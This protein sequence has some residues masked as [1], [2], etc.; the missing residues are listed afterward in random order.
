LF[1]SKINGRKL[2]YNTPLNEKFEK[3][4]AKSVGQ[5]FLNMIQNDKFVEPK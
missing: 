5:R 4:F 2:K 3:N 1:N